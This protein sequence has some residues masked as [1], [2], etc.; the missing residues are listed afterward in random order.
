MLVLLYKYFLYQSL[1]PTSPADTDYTAPSRLVDGCGVC[2]QA[3]STA[4]RERERKYSVGVRELV[5][6]SLSAIFIFFVFLFVTRDF[7]SFLFS[8]RPDIFDISFKS[9]N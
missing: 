6:D 2:G 7:L 3:Q 5:T 8:Y 1:S 9:N 4:E